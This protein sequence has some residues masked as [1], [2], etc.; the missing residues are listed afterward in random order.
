MSNFGAKKDNSKPCV[1][2]HWLSLACLKSLRSGI[3]NY[4]WWSSIFFRS[5]VSRSHNYRFRR[6]RRRYRC[7]FLNRRLFLFPV[8]AN[9]AACINIDIWVIT[10]LHIAM[11]M[12]LFQSIYMLPWCTLECGSKL[13]FVFVPVLFIEDLIDRLDAD[14]E[15]FYPPRVQL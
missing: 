14:D 2:S 6:N 4:P 11:K 1:W 13:E 9:L 10:S 8:W 12:F 7:F 5:R 3:Q 15:L